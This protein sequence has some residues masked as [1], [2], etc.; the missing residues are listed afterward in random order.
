MKAPT[1]QWRSHR[2][3]ALVLG[4][5]VCTLAFTYGTRAD[6]LGTLRPGAEWATVSGPSLPAS[7]HFLAGGVLLGVIPVLLARWLLGRGFGSLG[8]GLGN[9]REGAFW[10]VVGIPIATLA[11]NIASGSAA[12]RSVYPFDL[13]LPAEPTKF[14]PHAGFG[15]LYYG[16]WEV[17]FRG[18]LLFGLRDRIG[19]G[20]A[21]VLQTALS[22]TAHF[23]RPIDETFSALPAGLV[24]GWIDLRVGSVWYVAIIHWVLGMSMEWFILAGAG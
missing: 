13:A 18:V 14:L 6:L 24:F 21:N 19:D 17:L 15:F 22:V 10:L 23:G 7:L 20:A 5:V 1:I 3:E 12:M 4:A 9:V 2:H 16:A 8:L 11:G